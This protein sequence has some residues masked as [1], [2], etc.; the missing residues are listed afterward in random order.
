MDK[1]MSEVEKRLLET[2]ARSTLDKIQQLLK[3]KD[4]VDFH[5]E[6]ILE[7][8]TNYIVRF[9]INISEKEADFFEKMRVD[10]H[11]HN[12]LLPKVLC[13][14]RDQLKNTAKTIQVDFKNRKVIKP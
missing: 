13:N 3:E 6:Y 1:E 4:G 2:K 12:G 5:K 11:D 7:K 14:K 10:M 8:I 9:N